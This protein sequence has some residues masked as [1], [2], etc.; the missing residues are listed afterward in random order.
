MVEL[1][2]LDQLT[3]M[4]LDQLKMYVEELKKEGYDISNQEIEQ[5]SKK[6]KEQSSKKIFMIMQITSALQKKKSDE[7]KEEGESK[8][9][10]LKKPIKIDPE[11]LSFDKLTSEQK[12]RY[13]ELSDKLTQKESKKYPDRITVY[14]LLKLYNITCSAKDKPTQ[15]LT[16]I[17]A[18]S[19]GL[20]QAINISHLEDISSSGKSSKSKEKEI[21]ERVPSPPKERVPSPPKERVPTEESKERVR[22][23][24]KERVRSASKERV[25]SASKEKQVRKPIKVDIKNLSLEMLTSE[26]KKRYNE[27]NDKLTQKESKKHPD[28][29]TVY[30][31]LKR[32]N[33][34]CSAKDKSTQIL[35]IVKA[36]SE[37]LVDV[38]DI[39]DLG[40]ISS[41]GK[42]KDRERSRS[43]SAE[44]VKDKKVKSCGSFS[45]EKLLKKRLDELREILKEKG[46]KDS[47]NMKKEKMVDIICQ[48]EEGGLCNTDF[49]CNNPNFTC[50][51]ST[52][53]GICVNEEFNSKYGEN[54]YEYKG[55]KIVGSK[56]AIESFKKYIEDENE[57]QVILQKIIELSDDVKEDNYKDKNKQELLEILNALNSKETKSSLLKQINLMIGG[58]MEKYSQMTDKKLLNI[59]SKEEKR[60]RELMLKISSIDPS[61]M[62]KYENMNNNEIEQIIEG[63]E[64]EVQEDENRDGDEVEYIVSE[65]ENKY[66]GDI[67]SD[68]SLN[69]LVKIMVKALTKLKSE[70]NM[71]DEELLKQMK[72]WFQ[73]DSALSFFPKEKYQRFENKVLEKLQGKEDDKLKD[74]RKRL[75]SLKI[76]K[77]QVEVH[78]E[79][80][81]IH[82]STKLDLQSKLDVIL[83]DIGKLEV[84]ISKLD[85]SKKESPRMER[86]EEEV[87][88]EKV[89]EGE[90]VVQE[91]EVVD[92][93]VDED[94]EVKEE[95]EEEVVQM[96][97]EKITV[98]DIL[99]QLD[100]LK[101][102]NDSAVKKLSSVQK[103][104]VKCLGLIS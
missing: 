47:S 94:E 65:M 17:K 39:S 34:S 33:I 21:I 44:R 10:Q 96:D 9:K 42:S 103:Q 32:Y 75:K 40:D 70:N 74:Y 77:R 87:Q 90:V 61:N 64:V 102:G 36:E 93:V 41:S 13:N 23:A 92:E 45:Y 88:E 76:E 82:M 89:Q 46:V 19:E 97:Q 35:T 27:L 4:S 14:G 22:S 29:I 58:D 51:L 43:K 16:I 15:I 11:N 62:K 56:Q 3:I 98:E 95:V 69:S 8:Q 12:K 68:S 71:G 28:R 73:N 50:N 30:G 80:K 101:D 18:E 54:S 78:L 84:K 5:K 20:V 83:A 91:G 38:V 100:S 67:P 79:K 1:L 81:R 25:R 63:L 57:R 37:G 6:I 49:S 99:K 72:K 53:P 55:N 24:S 66:Y 86:V 48:S 85:G 59:I 104:I 52:K 7:S 2:N 26:Q 31:L 60:R